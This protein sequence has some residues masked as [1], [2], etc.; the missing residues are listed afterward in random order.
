MVSYGLPVYHLTTTP[1]FRQNRL[2][3]AAA[4]AHQPG[5]WIT[6][7]AGGVGEFLEHVE[8]LRFVQIGGFLQWCYPQIIHFNRI[9]HYQP[10]I[11][12]QQPWV[13]LLEMIILGC[14][15]GTTI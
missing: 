10:S 6:Q 4:V 13:F 15:G 9:F 7:D 8:L 12:T 5:F 1:H 3:V 11:F 14:F 2:P